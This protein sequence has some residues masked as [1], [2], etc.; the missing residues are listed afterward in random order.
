MGRG[1]SQPNEV[2]ALSRLGFEELGSFAGGIGGI[3]RAIADRV[4]RAVGPQAAPVRVIHDT[5]SSGV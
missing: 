4:F 5:V 1:V 2:G 3:H